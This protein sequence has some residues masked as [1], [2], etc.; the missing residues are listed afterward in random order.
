MD[1]EQM[2]TQKIIGCAMEVHRTLGP[3]LLES[4]YEGALAVELAT[5]GIRFDRQ[6][7]V[8]MRY[9]GR[10]VGDFKVDL[11]VESQ[12]IVEVKSVTRLDPVFTAQVLTYLR[13]TGLQV[14]L[15]LNFG[16]PILSD[17][18]RRIVLTK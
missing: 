1:G 11:I 10:E 2:L 6:V 8:P 17:G 9:R 3:G 16:R 15:L 13:I 12:V 7:V 5:A 14:G 4:T 18:V